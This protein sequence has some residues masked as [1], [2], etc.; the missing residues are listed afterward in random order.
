MS[1][2]K[3]WTPTPVTP[4]FC[5]IL[6]GKHPEKY[7]PIAHAKELGTGKDSIWAQPRRVQ[8]QV[9]PSVASEKNVL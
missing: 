9:F 1:N 5:R 4:Q 6:T 3:G 8:L 2:P 7:K